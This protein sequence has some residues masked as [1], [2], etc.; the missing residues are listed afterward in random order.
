VR[1]AIRAFFMPTAT[2]RSDGAGDG[3]SG[4][5]RSSVISLPENALD[6]LGAAQCGLRLL[7]AGAL[8]ADLGGEI[9]LLRAQGF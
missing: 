7:H 6:R 5:P 1:L 2:T 4:L 3:A 9:K 8:G